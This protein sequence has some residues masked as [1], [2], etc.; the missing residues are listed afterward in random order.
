MNPGEEIEIVDAEVVDGEAVAPERA[1]VFEQ[2]FL[3]DQ[4]RS[5]WRLSISDEWLRIHQ[6]DVFGELT[7]ILDELR[8]FCERENGMINYESGYRYPRS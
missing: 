7:S 4:H 8:Q 3:R 1:L 6:S 2:F 5:I